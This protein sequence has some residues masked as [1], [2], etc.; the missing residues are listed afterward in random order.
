MNF[1]AS[2]ARSSSVL[3]SP[4]LLN[5]SIRTLDPQVNLPGEGGKGSLFDALEDTN[6]SECA[7]TCAAIAKANVDSLYLQVR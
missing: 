2:P 4:R 1:L 3:T 5:G 7:E 6:A